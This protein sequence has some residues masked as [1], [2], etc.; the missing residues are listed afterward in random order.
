M[1]MGCV[2]VGRKLQLLLRKGEDKETCI[3]NDAE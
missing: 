3:S 1:V 2:V